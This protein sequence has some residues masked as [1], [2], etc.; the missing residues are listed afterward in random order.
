MSACPDCSYTTSR[1]QDM[2]IHRR[3]HT[4]ERPYPCPKCAYAAISTSALRLHLL[5]H[6][7]HHERAHR[8]PQCDFPYQVRLHMRTHTDACAQCNFATAYKASLRSHLCTPDKPQPVSNV[9]PAYECAWC[10]TEFSSI[11]AVRV[12]EQSHTM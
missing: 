7:E 8:C 4:G 9:L 12:C 2:A 5:S 10:G 1:P 3:R 6:R 11:I